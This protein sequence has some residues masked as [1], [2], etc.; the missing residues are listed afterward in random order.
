MLGIWL[1]I[2]L[3]GLTEFAGAY[4]RDRQ[5]LHRNRLLTWLPVPLLEIIAGGLLFGSLIP[6]AMLVHLF[7]AGLLGIVVLSPA[8]PDIKNLLRRFTRYSLAA[9]AF[10]VCALFFMLIYGVLLEIFPDLNT[11]IVAA[12]VLILASLLMKPAFVLVSQAS[13]MLVPELSEQSAQIMRQ[14]TRN[15]RTGSTLDGLTY[16]ITHAIQEILPVSEVNILNVE[17]ASEADQVVY[18]ISYFKTFQ[19][20][21][22]HS[23]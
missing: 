6:A 8:L 9:S 7:A 2:L 3:I 5:P 22:N 17:K 13:L 23:L 19:G 14:F 20:K 21:Q 4:R 16:Q 15:L 11:L 18:I 1:V 10:F 12:A